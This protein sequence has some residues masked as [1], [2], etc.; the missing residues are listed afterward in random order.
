MFF[1]LVNAEVKKE[2]SK[3]IFLRTNSKKSYLQNETKV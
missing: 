3:E 1:E 2:G